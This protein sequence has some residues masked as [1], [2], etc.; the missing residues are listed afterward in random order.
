MGGE[1]VKLAEIIDPTGLSPH[2]ARSRRLA[3]ARRVA[4]HTERE[5]RLLVH[6]CGYRCV[7]CKVAG[8]PLDKDH[9]VPLCMGGHDGLANLQP[10]CPSC[11]SSKGA[12]TR[13]Y[14]PMMLRII[15]E[16]E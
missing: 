14:R 3:A 12:T 5:W 8:E 6:A 4:K 13:D 15:T 1:E 10:L 16:L 9:I 2:Q 7:R 11:N